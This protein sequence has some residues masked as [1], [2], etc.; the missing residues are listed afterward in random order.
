MTI[1]TRRAFVVLGLA[2][3]GI[4]GSAEVRGDMSISLDSW[5]PP[6]VVAIVQGSNAKG[7]SLRIPIAASMLEPFA[8]GRSDAGT[9]RAVFGACSFFRTLLTSNSGYVF[10]LIAC[11]GRRSGFGNA[12]YVLD[13]EFK[14]K[15]EKYE[16]KC[17]SGCSDNIPHRFT[18]TE[19]VP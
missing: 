10:S 2:S 18:V 17:V 19:K 13:D 4:A 5:L 7:D 14:A 1:N 12:V 6:D 15:P 9:R 16:L 3:V 8:L 11:D